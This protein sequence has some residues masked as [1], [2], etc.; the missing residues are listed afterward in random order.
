[1]K[2]TEIKKAYAGDIISIA[3]IEGIDIG[4]TVADKDIPAA[5]PFID[6]DEPTLAMDIYAE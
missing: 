4:E 3:G 5:L 2:R 6:I 1:M